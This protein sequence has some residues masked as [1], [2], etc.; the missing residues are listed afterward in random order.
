MCAAYP[1]RRSGRQ[2][3]PLPKLFVIAIEPL[4]K[5]IREDPEIQGVKVGKT[6]H[7]INLM[8]DDIIMYLTNQFD[9]LAKLQTVLH[10]LGF[11]L[12]YK[13]NKEKSEILQLS[14]FDYIEHQQGGLFKWSP[15]G[16]RYVG[17][18]MGNHPSSS[19]SGSGAAA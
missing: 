3:C 9:S 8:A 7:Q 12:G 4:A 10:T 15:S 6:T 17:I 13:V 18:M 2:E 16:R 19:R 1:L 11:I 5:K 14:K